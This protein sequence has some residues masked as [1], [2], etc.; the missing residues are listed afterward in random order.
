MIDAA[1]SQPHHDGSRRTSRRRMVDAVSTSW[2]HWRS[3][4]IYMRFQLYKLVLQQQHL[5]SQSPFPP[6]HFGGGIDP[7]LRQS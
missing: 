3:A 4:R 6:P 7:C 1:W 2:G 5:Y